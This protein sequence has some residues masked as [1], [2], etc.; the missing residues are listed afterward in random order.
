MYLTQKAQE[1]FNEEKKTLAVF[2]DVA[3]AFDKVWHLGVIYKLYLMK[4][5]FYF[6][7]LGIS[8]RSH[9]CS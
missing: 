3:A 6:N 5:P 4:V 7:Y 1:G 9:I 2:F 8:K